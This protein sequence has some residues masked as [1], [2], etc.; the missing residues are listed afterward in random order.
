VSDT[1]TKVEIVMITDEAFEEMMGA[2]TKA[3]QL[4]KEICER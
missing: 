4:F 1:E 3:L 2:W